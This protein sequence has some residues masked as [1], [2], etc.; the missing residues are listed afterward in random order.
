MKRLIPVLAIAAL[1][2]LALAGCSDYYSSDEYGPG[3]EAPEE[4]HD[5]EAEGD[6]AARQYLQENQGSPSWETGGSG[7]T[8]YYEPTMN[9]DWHDDAVC[10]NGSETVRPYLREWDDFVTEAELMESAYEYAA[11]LNGG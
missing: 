10:G 7:W 2:V 4:Y 3:P 8:C 6:A 11:Q 1:L 5:Y 9:E